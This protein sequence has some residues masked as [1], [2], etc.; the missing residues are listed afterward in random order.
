MRRQGW[1]A[2]SCD[3]LPC[4]GGRAEWHIQDD[5]LATA[6]SRHW[7]LIISFP[8]CTDLAVSGA[9]WFAGKR[10]D[11]SQRESI[12]F[13]LDI[14][15]LSDL[16]E[17]PVGIMSGGKYLKKHFPDLYERWL[18]IEILQQKPQVI[19]P[20]DHGH[21]E[22]KATCLW[23][24]GLPA[25]QPSDKVEGREGRVWRMPPSADRAKNRSK[26]FTGIARAMAE[27]YT[28]YYVREMI[29]L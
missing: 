28:A 24:K 4:S 17:N 7:D 19:Q 11:G 13:F 3:L 12:K 27:Q 6:R 16:V 26:T 1:E 23:T 20:H 8:P 14:A 15:E 29:G 10:A 9:R 21:G 2:F 25:L 22:T 5:A 18:N